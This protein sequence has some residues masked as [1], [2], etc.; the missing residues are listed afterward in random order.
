MSGS[1]KFSPE[2]FARLIVGHDVAGIQDVSS[3]G[4]FLVHSKSSDGT[5][6]VMSLALGS[7]SGTGFLESSVQAA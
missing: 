4:V 7:S 5:L 6:N 2:D 1:S 3:E